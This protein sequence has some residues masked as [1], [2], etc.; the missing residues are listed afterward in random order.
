MPSPTTVFEEPRPDQLRA[1]S[2]KI[3]G[4][5]SVHS[6]TLGFLP[7]PAN[8]DR[9]PQNSRYTRLYRSQTLT[10]V[11]RYIVYTLHWMSHLTPEFQAF[12]ETRVPEEVVP[13]RYHRT[14][15]PE[16]RWTFNFSEDIL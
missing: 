14:Y 9:A 10:F 5:S 7:R 11:A 13:E 1:Y 2:I 16:P 15:H 3:R 12:Y 6:F 8:F 4:G